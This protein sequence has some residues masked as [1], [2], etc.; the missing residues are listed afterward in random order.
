MRPEPRWPP[1]IEGHVDLSTA[2]ASATAIERPGDR[3]STR[4]IAVVVTVYLAIVV[5]ATILPLVFT[6]NPWP[7]RSPELQAYRLVLWLLWLAVLVETMRRHPASPMWR[8]VF[9]YVVAA[10]FSYFAYLPSSHVATV[11]N[12]VG[13]MYIPI[14]VHLLLAFPTGHLKAGW[15]RAIVGFYYV[16]II[17]FSLAVSA[18]DDLPPDP[19]CVPNCY[20]NLLFLWSNPELYE[21]LRIASVIVPVAAIPLVFAR[22]WVHWR[23]A[24]WVGRR[25][26]LPVLIASP[27]IGFSM[28]LD[29]SADRFSIGPLSDFYSSAVGPVPELVLPLA[30]LAGMLRLRLGKGRTAELLVDLGRGVPIG[31]LQDRL[32]TTL[33]DPTLQLVFPAP[34]GEGFVDASGREVD[35]EASDS[36]RAITRLEHDDELLGLLIHDPD[37]DNEDPGLL[38]AVGSAATLALENERLAAQVR[39]QLEEVRASRARIVEAGDAER[40]RVERDLHDGAQQRLVAIA[41]RLQ[42]ARETSAGATEILDDATAE[43]RVAIDEVR[44]LARGLHPTI[45]TEAGL[46]AAIEALA[47]RAPFA[48]TTDVI[49]T[50][51]PPTIE[52]TAYFVIAE[53]LT[54]VARHAD[55]TEALVTVTERDRRLVVIVRDFGRGGAGQGKGSGLKG[56]EDRLAALG[57][58]LRVDSRPGAGTILTAELPLI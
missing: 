58:T 34:A 45:L 35:V 30:L 44:S 39:A 19:R 51:Y 37:L 54:N 7:D 21:A 26:I 47:E 5:A 11:A 2:A 27:V 17:A 48:V 36:T 20:E 40:R 3:A 49:E 32:A 33:G 56:L 12:L 22:L 38:E 43:L 31:G 6:R 8:L 41:L 50:R 18:V 23:D 52:A 4:R 15:D 10:N 42:T 13:T 53:A 14:L 55:A 16:E 1:A 28:A 9:A 25:A 57:G 46:A 29:Y 24:R